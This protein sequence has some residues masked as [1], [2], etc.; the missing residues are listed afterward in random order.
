MATGMYPHVNGL[1]G[2][3][4]LGWDIPPANTLLP[5]ALHDAGYETLL[6]GFQHIAA[7]PSRVGYDHVS[8]R[9][10]YGCRAVASAVVDDL[11]QRS[12]QAERPF[13]MEVGFSEVHRPY[14]GLEQTPPGEEDIRPLPFLEDTPGLRVDLAM[15]Y[16]SIRRMDQSVG[17]ILGALESQQLAQ[18]T[19]VVFTTDHGIAF[20]RAKATLYDPGIRTA[21]LMRW[22]E[23]L[24]GGQSIPA[25]TSNVDLFTT[26]VHI[27]RGAPPDGGNGRSLLPLARGEEYEARTAVFA[28]KNT[29]AE[30]IKRCVRT[31]EHKYI[32]NYSEGPQL[33]LPTDIEVT[34]TRRDMGDEHLTPRPSVELYD[35]ASDPWEQVNVA[36][37][38]EYSGVQRELAARLQSILEDTHDPVLMGAIPRP[39]GEAEI[40]SRIWGAEAMQ[41]RASREAEIHRTYEQMR[42]ERR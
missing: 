24:A 14:G 41:Q 3:V 32:V 1:M 36:G 35:L 29:S 28:E 33:L 7:D 39:A 2:L 23:G 4:N 9:G 34:A 17:E 31:A 40:H 42:K 27:A 16:E 8:E 13:Y 15:F 22:P 5:A 25:M 10:P 37:E 18:N 19:V 26:L 30:D 20:P 12:A 21:L 6:F 38:P 11:K